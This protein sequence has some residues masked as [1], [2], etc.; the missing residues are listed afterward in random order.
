[1]IT[2]ERLRVALDDVELLAAVSFGV[3]SGEALA[4]TG[5]N[6]S[7]KTTLLSVIA[8]LVRPTEGTITVH[9]VVPDERRREFRAL[10]ATLVGTPPA[11][12]NL[13][14]REHLVL[15]G[16]SWGDEVSKAEERADGLLRDLAILKLAARFPHEL[17]SGQTQL[18]T[19]ALTLSRPSGVLLLDEPEQRLDD[20]RV[21]LVSEV[22]RRRLD[23]GTTVVFTSHSSSLV[24]QLADR[25]L[26]L[27]DCERAQH[28]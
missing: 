17:S 7:G 2:A 5:P 15:V 25:T 22:L 28:S 14:L 24:K 16:A 27:A 11:A 23:D 20:E 9:G 8:G 12:R 19:L 1:M 26:H 21:Q 18:F 10:V 13:T 3:G 6:G 4:V